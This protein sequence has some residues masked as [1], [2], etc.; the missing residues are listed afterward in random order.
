M[1]ETTGGIA[2]EV[3]TN[4]ILEILTNEIYDSPNALLRE[5]I[6]NAYDAI[7][8]RCADSGIS[9][10]DH[11]IKVSIDDNSVVIEDDGI[12]MTEEVLR[13]NFWKAGSSGKKTELARR[14][15][16]V[17]TFGIGAMANFG[18]CSRL[19]VTTRTY[20]AQKA[21]QCWAERGQLSFAA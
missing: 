19:E 7:L 9:P 4:R 1:V 18:V 3:E 5:N 6:Q 14:A 17:G 8:M 2:F 12:G 21:V 11:A 13:G 20:G 15:G 10:T 16:V